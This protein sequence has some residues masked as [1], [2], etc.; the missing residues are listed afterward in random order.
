LTDL[1]TVE[2]QLESVGQL[3]VPATVNRPIHT[4]LTVRLA[5]S[6]ARRRRGGRAIPPDGSW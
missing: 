3:T 6:D 5:D 1:M 2:W 4:P